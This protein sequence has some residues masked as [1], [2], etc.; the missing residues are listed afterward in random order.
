MGTKQKLER[1]T[2]AI[3]LLQLAHIPILILRKIVH[4]DIIAACTD[5]AMT[6]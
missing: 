3:F 2:K 6:E 5:I 4:N 1:S